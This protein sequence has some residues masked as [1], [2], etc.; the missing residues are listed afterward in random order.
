MCLG[1]QNTSILNVL[2]SK[3]EHLR[4]NGDGRVLLRLAHDKQHFLARLTRKSVENLGLAEGLMVYA[5]IKSVALLT[6]SVIQVS[7]PT[8]DR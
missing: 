6:E 3:I 4:D 7:E 5:Q 8:D 2:H 1:D